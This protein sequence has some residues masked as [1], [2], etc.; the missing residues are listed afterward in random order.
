MFD[1]DLQHIQ[2]EENI[3]ADAL[4]RIY[5]GMDAD[6]IVEQDYLKEEEN[7]INTN[8]FLPDDPPSTQYMS[9]KFPI[10]TPSLSLP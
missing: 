4:S 1:F 2:G 9:C 7:Y 5:D 8:T 10:T 3:L 6:E